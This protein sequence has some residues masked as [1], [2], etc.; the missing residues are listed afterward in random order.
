MIGGWF[1][2]RTLQGSCLKPY[3]THGTNPFGVN[4]ARSPQGQKIHL[5]LKVLE[6]ASDTARGSRLVGKDGVE[7]PAACSDTACCHSHL[8]RPL[9]REK[10]HD[11]SEALKPLAL[12]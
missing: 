4:E 7:Q 10:R 3:A 11:Q 2:T 6:E 5:T 12:K 9:T 1:E 8:P